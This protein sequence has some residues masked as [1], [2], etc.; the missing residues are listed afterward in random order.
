LLTNEGASGAKKMESLD[1]SDNEDETKQLL[2]EADQS[3]TDYYRVNDG[4][5]GTTRFNASLSVEGNSGELKNSND[6]LSY[7]HVKQADLSSH[8]RLKKTTTDNSRYGLASELTSKSE[9]C[10]YQKAF[11]AV[12]F[13]CW[14][15]HNGRYS[16]DVTDVE[17][18]NNSISSFS[19][20][21]WNEFLDHCFRSNFDVKQCKLFLQNNKKWT[22]MFDRWVIIKVVEEC[23]IDVVKCLVENVDWHDL[24]DYHVLKAAIDSAKNPREKLIYFVQERLVNPYSE[25]KATQPVPI[26]MTFTKLSLLQAFVDDCSLDVNKQYSGSTTAIYRA[27]CR[28]ALPAALFLL[29]RGA[30]CDIL[31]ANYTKATPF[32]NLCCR[33]DEYKRRCTEL[34]GL[35]IER[36]ESAILRRLLK[37]AEIAARKTR[38]GS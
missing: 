21:F 31:F 4:Y 20:I 32:A 17:Q 12:G 25:Y 18:T 15:Q 19:R 22:R 11:N 7:L 16:V 14:Q 37:A 10:S 28:N 6:T 27:V 8:D 36:G 29:W 26:E 3:I 38:S 2:L 35:A 13:N 24:N 1:A 9:K 30:D 34:L 23:S 33:H 5:C